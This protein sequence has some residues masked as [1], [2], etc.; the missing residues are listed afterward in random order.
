VADY[1]ARYDGRENEIQIKDK[2]GN[3]S[4]TFYIYRIN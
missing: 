2:E 3:F 1:L 4:N